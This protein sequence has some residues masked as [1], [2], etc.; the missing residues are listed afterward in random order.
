MRFDIKSTPLLV[1]LTA[2]HICFVHISPPGELTSI[3]CFM[4][5]IGRLCFMTKLYDMNE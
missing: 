1:I 5:A 2:G 4:V 3:V